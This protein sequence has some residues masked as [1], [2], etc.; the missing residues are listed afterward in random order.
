MAIFDTWSAKARAEHCKQAASL[1]FDAI[2]IGGGITGAGVARELALRGMSFC[3][4]DKNDF[5]F[6]TSS[7]SSK[8]AHGGIRYLGNREFKL[9]RESTTERNW[10][11]NHFPNMVRPLGFYFNSFAK[12]KD[13]PVHIIYTMILY[14]VL[15]G[16]RSKFKNYRLPKIYNS[17]LMKRAEPNFTRNE[18]T[19]GKFLISGFY[20]DTNIDDARLTIETIKESLNYSKGRSCALNYSEVTGFLKDGSGKVCGVKVRDTLDGHEYEVKGKIVIACGGIWTDE[21]LK[22]EDSGTSRIYPT[23]GVHVVVP[24]ERIGNRNGLGLRSFDDNRFFFVLRRGKVSVI[25]TTDTDYFKES[26]NLDEPWC[27]K[28]DCD[29]LFRTV[30]RM[31]PKANL[32]YKDII[33]TYAGIRPLIK[34]EG[35]ASESAVSRE[36][37]IFFLKNGV[38][39]I[40][41]GKLTT[42]R[43]MAEELIFKLIEKGYMSAFS[44]PEHSIPGFSMQPF[45]VGMKRTDFNKTIKNKALAGVSWPDQLE[46]LYTQYGRQAID[47][48]EKIKSDPESGKSL[49]KD[50]PI[51][52]AEIEFILEYENCPRL[53][54]ILC[55]RTESQWTIWHYLQAELAEKVA[56][57]AAGYYGWDDARKETEIRHYNEYIKKTIWF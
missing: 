30:N 27:T 25:G 17:W 5:A 16:F 10:L 47:I 48:L 56:E 26:K 54:D 21:I 45:V 40:A 19:L 29:Y 15:S 39:A 11:R 41:G 23:K 18:E 3:I 46:Y 34:Q 55:R 43:L 35:A 22:N 44:V 53:I 49:L 4:L 8:L 50:Y 9:V 51:C 1:N 33:G 13:K 14:S 20:Y 6:G 32:T 36:H 37:E 38:V 2:I 31:F 57:I 12:G 24:N 28:E 42:F 52:R 7:R